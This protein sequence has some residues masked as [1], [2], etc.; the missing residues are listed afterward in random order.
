[1]IRYPSLNSDSVSVP[2]FGRHRSVLVTGYLRILE[3]PFGHGLMQAC[4]EE[5]AFR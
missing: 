3:I 4:R 5:P 2:E 1:M